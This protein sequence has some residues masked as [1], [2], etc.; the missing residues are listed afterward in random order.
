MVRILFIF[1]INILESNN[2]YTHKSGIITPDYYVFRPNPD[3]K[4]V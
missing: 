1:P 3:F 4:R 2:F